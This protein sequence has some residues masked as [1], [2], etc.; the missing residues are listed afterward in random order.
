[1]T[2]A[3]PV[4]QADA[5]VVGAGAYGLSTAYHL[6]RLGVGR[7]VL[8]DQY[9]PGTQVSAR[10]AGLFKLVQTSEVM[11]RLAQLSVEIVTSFERE[12]GVAMRHVRSGSLLVARTPRHAAML[13]AEAED[14][15]GWGVEIERIDGQEAHRRCRYLDGHRL[16]AAYHIPG[17]IFVDE[18]R[19]MLIAYRQ[20]AERLGVRV[21]GHT[22]A[23]GVRTEGDE[24]AAVVTPHGEIQTP[25]VVDT[26]G[27]WAGALG[28]AA[29]AAVLVQPVRHQLRITAP[30]EGVAPDEPIARIVD[31][32]VYVR[33]ARGGLM[34]GGFEHD[35]LAM[36]SPD[37]PGFT[38][39]MVPLDGR[40]TDRFLAEIG[41]DIP[42]LVGTSAQEERG[43]LFTM[44]ADGF[45]LV[46]PSRRVRGFWAATGCNGTGFS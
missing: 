25:V 18:P 5:V 2:A 12:S 23:T 19:S 26:A 41:E 9:E 14:A 3:L 22:P 8:L 24:V 39:D 37:G 4:T 42:V 32:A 35:P 13:D 29:G 7:V 15:R 44:T 40:V 36:A 16:L 1:M 45:P 38:I 30:I 21:L 27:V 10:A 11:T 46:G 28:A 6:A 34:Y 20:A 43:G 33:P 17:D 31:T